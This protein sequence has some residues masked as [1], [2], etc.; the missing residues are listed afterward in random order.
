VKVEVV[1]VQHFVWALVVLGLVQPA[2]VEVVACTRL[3]EPV[4]VPLVWLGLVL[5]RNFCKI[6]LLDLSG[7]RIF[8]STA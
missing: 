8:L 4:Q 6:L 7:F 1:L 5:L 3:V 2:V